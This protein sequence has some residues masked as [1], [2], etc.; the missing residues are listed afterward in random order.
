M[1][2]ATLNETL[3]SAPG[4]GK[5]TFSPG[6]FVPIRPVWI[7]KGAAWKEGNELSTGL[8]MPWQAGSAAS[9]H[10]SLRWDAAEQSETRLSAPFSG[11]A[12]GHVSANALWQPAASGRMGLAAGWLAGPRGG[13][14]SRLLWAD[15]AGLGVALASEWIGSPR[16]HIAKDLDWEKA[17]PFAGRNVLPWGKGRI[18]ARPDA[19][20]WQKAGLPLWRLHVVRPS[21]Q[22]GGGG[23]HGGRDPFGSWQIFLRRAYHMLH[24]VSLVRLP[25][26]IPIHASRLSFQETA[27]SPYIQF[28]GVIHGR[29]ALDAVIPSGG[30]PV[31]LEANVNGRVV[32]IVLDAPK[33]SEKF[34]ANSISI[35]G[36]SRSW[37]LGFPCQMPR[38]RTSSADSTAQALANDELQS[39]IVGDEAM[40]WTLS[41]DGDWTVPAK[42]LSYNA[43]TPLA[44]IQRIAAAARHVVVPSRTDKALAIR[45]R[46]PVLPWDYAS[47][48]PNLIVPAGASFVPA[49]AFSL[50]IYANAVYV[51]GGAVGG[52][53]GRI[54]KS[55]TAGDR[56]LPQIQDDLITHSDAAYLRGISE[57]AG[58]WQQPII[59][60][61]SLPLDGSG[62]PLPELG[63]LVRVDDPKDGTIYGTV[64]GIEWSVTITPAPGGKANCDVTQTLT[65]GEDSGDRLTLYRALQPG[66]PLIYGVVV[67]VDGTSLNIQRPDGTYLQARGAASIG[68]HVYVRSGRVDSVAPALPF[69]DLEA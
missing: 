50:P 40:G 15:A 1:Y 37:Y 63:W 42:A 67:S 54:W 17:S 64:T 2:V 61:I 39:I 36:R 6:A 25:D 19:L 62:F 9:A 60:S 24:D 13:N 35:S 18:A 52:V 57:L 30:V 21:P 5:G 16:G 47:A 7:R 33:A 20:A 11:S 69:Y 44:A 32:R 22:P 3:I 46:Y 10:A 8:A 23:D 27:D 12:A 68:E 55:G 14:A 66:D 45:P 38:S 34:G 53:L 41:W 56:L 49:K 26:R 28:T 43:L 65:L 29:A 31:E 58:Q 48:T 4:T 51:A 59:R